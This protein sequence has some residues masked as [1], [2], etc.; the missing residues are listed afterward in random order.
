M[1]G[2]PNST[3][4]LHFKVAREC[5]GV[6]KTQLA[7]INMNKSGSSVFRGCIEGGRRGDE[8]FGTFGSFDAKEVFD[9][10]S[11]ESIRTHYFEILN[12]RNT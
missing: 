2:R 6:F 9:T 10:V 5:T 8:S 4:H 11:C 3:F 12:S 7:R 1:S